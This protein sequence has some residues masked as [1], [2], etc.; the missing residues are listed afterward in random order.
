MKLNRDSFLLRLAGTGLYFLSFVILNLWCVEAIT[1][2]FFH[3]IDQIKFFVKFTFLYAF[4]GLGLF[5]LFQKF[6]KTTIFILFLNAFL[7]FFILDW[8]YYLRGAPTLSA[9]TSA[10]THNLVGLISLTDYVNLPILLLCLLLFLLQAAG[11]SFSLRPSGQRVGYLFL[12]GW[13]GICLLIFSYALVHHTPPWKFG[14]WSLHDSLERRSFLVTWFAEA[15]DRQD[16]RVER[17]CSDRRVASLPLFAVEDKFVILQVECLD[18]SDLEWKVKGEPLMPTLDRMAAEGLLFKVDGVRKM[19]SQNADYELLNT[20]V[21]NAMEVF[22]G[23]V[24]TYPDSFAKFFTKKGIPTYTYIGFSGN[25]TYVRSSYAKMGAQKN[26]FLEELQKEGFKPDP[27]TGALGLPPH[28]DDR[29]LFS[30]AAASLPHDKFF[31]VLI[32]MNMH[33]PKNA[34]VTSDLAGEEFAASLAVI[35]E[36]D[37]ALK[38]LLDALPKG[39]TVLVIGDHTS[40]HGPRSK[41][42]PCV[43]YKKGANLAELE[44]DIPRDTIWTRCEI[45]QYARRLFAMPPVSENIP[46]CAENR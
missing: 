6:S 10:F 3:K 12:F 17:T 45:S 7:S 41:F 38:I 23:F 11:L 14:R 46:L 31:S 24:N 18:W 9:L 22:Y 35:R 4:A 16:Y 33:D 34:A 43:I 42:V 25:S 27:R 44:K 40:Y 37:E 39:T 13:G 15:C 8:N 26:Y 36:T 29:D 19:S 30:F 2:G 21:A 1:G 20:R 32:T 28:V 5:A